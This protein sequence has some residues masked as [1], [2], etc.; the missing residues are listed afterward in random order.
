M[1][2]LKN[3][4]FD[5]VERLRSRAEWLK[6]RIAARKTGHPDYDRGELSSL[7]WAI[8]ILEAYLIKKHTASLDANTLKA[9][10][11]QIPEQYLDKLLEAKK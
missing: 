7:E 10:G 4:E 5:R 11:H 9:I 6:K 2:T 1:K 8:P 3:R